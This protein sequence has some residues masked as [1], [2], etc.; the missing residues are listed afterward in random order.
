MPDTLPG[1]NPNPAPEIPPQTMPGEAPTPA[2][3]IDT[4]SPG[5]MIRKA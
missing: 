2:P 3:D 4:P 1:E 5:W